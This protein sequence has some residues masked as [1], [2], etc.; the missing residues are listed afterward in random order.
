M[1][2]KSPDFDQIPALRNLWKQAFGD[3]DAFLDAFFRLG[4]STDRSRCLM[5]DGQLAAM[6]Y[7]FD[8]QWDGRK[9][10]YLYAIATDQ[11]LQNRGLC[12]RLMDNTHTFLKELG[13]AGCVLVPASQSLFRFYGSLGYLPFGPVDCFTCTPSQSPVQLQQISWETY[14]QLRSHYLPA[15]S[16]LQDAQTLRFL[17]SYVTFYVAESCLFC[18]SMD[19]DHFIAQEF[20]GDPA[21]A[22]GIVCALQAQSG[23]FRTPGAGAPLAMFYPFSPDLKSPGYL[24]LVLD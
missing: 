20:L 4:F 17:A 9:L 13:Y 10:A 6:L 12:H 5:L 24:G 3:S 18:G 14:A 11:A 2:I 7:W 23:H 8:A 1:T 15:D 22:A 16:I 21:H 19:K